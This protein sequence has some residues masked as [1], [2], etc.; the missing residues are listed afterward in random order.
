MITWENSISNC[1]WITIED[2]DRNFPVNDYQRQYR[3]Y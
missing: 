1:R 2:S 3:W